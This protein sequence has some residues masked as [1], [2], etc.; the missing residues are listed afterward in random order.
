MA[1]TKYP[2][3]TTVTGNDYE[4]D[5]ENRIEKIRCFYED[6]VLYNKIISIDPAQQLATDKREVETPKFKKMARTVR[7]EPEPAKQVQQKKDEQLGLF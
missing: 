6:P 3:L 2:F 5:R 1:Q 4:D 7:A